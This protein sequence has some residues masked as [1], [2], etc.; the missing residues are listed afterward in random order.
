MLGVTST[1]STTATRPPGRPRSAKVEQAIIEATLDLLA[2]G[3]TI[4]GLSIEAV[5]ARAGVG[6]TTIYRRW[7]S[8]EELVIDAFSWLKGPMP[9]LPGR[10]VRE[11]LIVI[12]RAMRKVSRESREGK[13]YPCMMAESLR[14]PELAERFRVQVVE[15][16]REVI[17]DVLRRGIVT[18]ELRPDLDVEL[19]LALVTSPMHSQTVP[20]WMP[21]LNTQDLPE[22]IVDA[23]LEG[24]KG[25]GAAAPPAG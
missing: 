11:D 3:T 6:K 5:A 8:K 20:S 22:R 24:V 13:I 16:R 19:T 25:P 9:T 15:K 17:R 12:L 18:G 7:S 21:A 23:V 4:S 2:E 1:T 14:H 10:S